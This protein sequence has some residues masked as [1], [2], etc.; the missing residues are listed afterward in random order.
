LNIEFRHK[1]N[2]NPLLINLL[3]CPYFT[4]PFRV[5]TPST[6]LYGAIEVFS[7]WLDESSQ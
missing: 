6:W 5:N 3:K 2:Y 7:G 1:S 4:I